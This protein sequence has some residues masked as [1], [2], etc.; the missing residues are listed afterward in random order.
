MMNACLHQGP[1]MTKL[2]LPSSRCRIPVKS[3]DASLNTAGI[4]QDIVDKCKLIHPSKVSET[5]VARMSR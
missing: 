1:W 2:A 5:R 3:L 4:A